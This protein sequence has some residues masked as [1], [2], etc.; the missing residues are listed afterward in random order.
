MAV[1]ST[2]LLPQ[3]HAVIALVL[4][5]GCGWPTLVSYSGDR[6]ENDELAFVGMS[7]SPPSQATCFRHFSQLIRNRPRSWEMTS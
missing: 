5:L 7:L 4:G 2:L 1:E 3:I 6:N